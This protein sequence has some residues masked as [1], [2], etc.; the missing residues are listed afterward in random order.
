MSLVEKARKVDVGRLIVVPMFAFFMTLSIMTLCREIKVLFPIN[1]VKSLLLIHRILTVCFYALV[2]FIYFLRSR[3]ILTSRSYVTNFIAGV[4]SFG[5]FFTLLFLGKPPLVTY[6]MLL[7]SDFVIAFGMVLSIYSIYSLGR[8]FSIIPQARKLVQSGPYRLVRH[9][10]YLGELIS[11]FGVIW[12]GLTI[13]RITLYVVLVI[14]QLYRAVQEEKLLASVF[15][16]Y[17]EYSSQTA[18]FI[19]GVY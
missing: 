7:L 14:C 9:P 19:P 10:I 18:R 3:P 8:S 4:A 12:A 16:E 6:G 15:P 5:P 11:I 13:P 17:K 1:L 2:I